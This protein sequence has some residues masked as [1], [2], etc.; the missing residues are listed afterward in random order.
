MNGHLCKI[1]FDKYDLTK[2]ACHTLGCMVTYWNMT[3]K[4]YVLE[5]LKI[6][7]V[8]ARCNIWCIGS[9]TIDKKYHC[10]YPNRVAH[11]SL[12]CY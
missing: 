9:W 3:L 10:L 8:N 6:A 7:D 1:L 2:W 11:S 5:N 4:K 12:G